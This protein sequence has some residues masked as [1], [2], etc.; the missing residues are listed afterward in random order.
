MLGLTHENVRRR[1]GWGQ[2][3]TPRSPWITIACVAMFVVSS[4]VVA[5]EADVLMYGI[6]SGVIF[7]AAFVLDWLRCRARLD[8]EARFA[9]DRMFWSGALLVGFFALLLMHEGQ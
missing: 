8:D 6:I 7:P 4:A 9:V 5:L 1:A 3:L 2:P